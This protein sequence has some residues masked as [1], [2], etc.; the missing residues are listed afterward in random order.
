MKNSRIFNLIIISFALLII[1]GSVL[2]MGNL[3][4]STSAQS[5]MEVFPS[6]K[7]GSVSLIRR[8]AGYEM[9]TDI[10]LNNSDQVS[11]YVDSS[12]VINIGDSS[13]ADISESS[14]LCIV[15]ASAK[16]ACFKVESGTVMFT[17][18]E[19]LYTVKNVVGRISPKPDS[20]FSMEAH[21]GTQ[22]LSVYKGSVEIEFLN[23][24]TTLGCG[25]CAI[26]TQNDDK[27]S[28]IS[29]STVSINRLNAFLINTLIDN[30]TEC[31]NSSELKGELEQRRLETEQARAEQAAHEAEIISQG[32]TVAVINLKASQTGEKAKAED[33]FTCTVQIRC[34]TI[35]NN[36]DRLTAGKNIYV[37][38]SG[39][40][41]DTSK[42]EF[43][44]GESVYDVLK[45]ACVHAGIP[46][47]YSWT[48]EYGGYYIEGIN[49]LY[50][51]DCGAQ[52][53]W[54]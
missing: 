9:K 22:T 28:S 47:E 4:G 45:R 13:V 43:V 41:L 11:T 2:L 8:N 46:L 33:I 14:N 51:F 24:K 19:T 18:Y 12:C 48:V 20:L 29:Y 53:G 6:S 15:N 30:N 1:T 27:E 54:M 40:I 44:Q 36:M 26:I 21:E 42:V 39:V 49:N 10:V 5:S 50:E 32:G 3:L 37:P 52:S 16:E 31:F 38:A 34:D 35:L 25:Q 23:E 17:T 7:T